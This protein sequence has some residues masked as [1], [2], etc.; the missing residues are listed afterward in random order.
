MGPHLPERPSLQTL[1]NPRLLLP[2]SRPLSKVKS[3]FRSFQNP[4]HAGIN[5]LAQQ[6]HSRVKAH[7]NVYYTFTRLLCFCKAH[8]TICIASACSKRLFEK[9]VLFSSQC[10]AEEFYVRHWWRAHVHSVCS[11]RCE[12][13][14]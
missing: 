13:V 2:L 3:E 12:G 7:P 4:K 8:R 14:I 6:V 9:N 11:D 10:H 5:V 1:R